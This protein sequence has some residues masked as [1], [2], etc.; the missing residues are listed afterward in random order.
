MCFTNLHDLK[1]NVKAALHMAKNL[2]GVGKINAP[3]HNEKSQC[4]NRP[5]KTALLCHLASPSLTNQ[6]QTYWNKS[7]KEAIAQT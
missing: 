7:N 1:I 6:T 3:K 4:S 5:E 2:S